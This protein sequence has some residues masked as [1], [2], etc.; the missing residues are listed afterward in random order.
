[1]K[2]IHYLKRSLFAINAIAMLALFI[3]A[4]AYLVDPDIMLI[5]AFFGL[6]FLPIFLINVGFVVFWSLS[7]PKYAVI[8]LAALIFTWV[9]PKKHINFWPSK[10]IVNEASFDVMSFNVRLFDLYNWGGNKQ[11]R[12]EILT[13]L[14]EKNPPIICFQEF[15]NTNDPAYFNTLDTIVKTIDARNVHED[16]TAIMHYGKSKF[17]IATFSKYP[18]IHKA[19][20]P[21]DTAANNVAIFTDVLVNGDTIRV[22]NI[23]LAS[24]YISGLEK[25]LSKHIENNDQD[26]QLKDLKLMASRIA[27]GFK[28]RANQ[29][30]VIRT[31]I[32]ASPYPVIV[33]GDLNDTPAS[34]SYHLLSEGLNDAFCEKGFV[35]LGST[36]IGLIPGLRIDFIL[37][38]PRLSVDAF[39][40]ESVS[41]S[42]H[43]PIIATL[44]VLEQ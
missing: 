37:I 32:D 14:Q 27:G 24:I 7:K 31:Y 20:I 16:Y 42:D 2:I 12:N 33:C 21:L 4:Y 25:D 28:R 6:S 11:T 10:S 13:Y 23:H 5:P 30:E 40:S 38:D 43:R 17:G 19:H 44:S 34:Y 26:G 8:G 9:A 41:L 22:F 29:A 1:L 18:I 39:S 35:G 36:Y 15:F 3:S